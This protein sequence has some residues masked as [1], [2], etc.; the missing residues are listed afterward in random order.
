MKFIQR[1][2]S[3]GLIIGI[4]A[5]AVLGF[6]YRAEIFPN[7]FAAPAE[8]G[9]QQSVSGS[10]AEGI[11]KRPEQS[12]TTGNNRL[13]ADRP[14]AQPSQESAGLDLPP[15]QDEAQVVSEAALP[16][17]VDEEVLAS[18][19]LEEAAP[20]STRS[21]AEDEPSIP[22]HVAGRDDD[23]QAPGQEIVAAGEEAIADPVEAAAAVSGQSQT[24]ASSATGNPSFST[25]QASNQQS[26]SVPEV[27]DADLQEARDAFWRRD[28]AAAE[29]HYQ[30]VIAADD[31]N[32]DAYGELGNLYFQ[33]GEWER[34]AS[35][36]FEAAQR[37]VASGQAQRAQAILPVL[38]G[39]DAERANELE[40]VLWQRNR[41]G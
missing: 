25:I 26:I 28:F 2:I 7:Q 27:A 35:A 24:T 18:Q 38:R 6:W 14:I 5:V 8:T 34:A 23:V 33:Q 32:A 17:L 36:Y 4:I 40:T 12:D 37:L 41:P 11:A 20:L 15:M 3:H 9:A 30:Q 13:A 39:L 29:E 31:A 22:E 1:V 21:D 10:E 16:P 19:Q